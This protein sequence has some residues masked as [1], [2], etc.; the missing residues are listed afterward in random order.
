MPFIQQPTQIDAKPVFYTIT[1][2]SP[3][4][5]VSFVTQKWAE[6]LAN[7]NKKV[8]IFDALLG[9]QNFPHHNPNAN[10][11]LSVLNGWRPLIDLVIPFKKKIDLITGVASQNINA[12]S[13]CN[14]QRL[15]NELQTL[16]V[17]YDVIFI[18]CPAAVT[19]SVF[20]TL[21]TPVWVSTTNQEILIKTLRALSVSSP[22]YLILNQV[23][24][25]A[26]YN[27]CSLLVKNFLPNCQ[28]IKFFK[29]TTP[30]NL[31]FL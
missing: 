15:L 28:I 8:L 3:H 26:Q 24:N 30:K 4:I 13:L 10:K 11:I 12:L 2:R 16:A 20:C 1:S 23:K 6:E 21:G 19:S 9:L 22:Q 7:Q 25:E 5:G 17:H 27:E 29:E 31:T 18:D 14:Q